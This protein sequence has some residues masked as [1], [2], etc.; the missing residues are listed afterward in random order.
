MGLAL[1]SNLPS[2]AASLLGGDVTTILIKQ[3]IRAQGSRKTPT[4]GKPVEKENPIRWLT[5]IPITVKLQ[6]VYT[7][8]SEVTQHAVES[9]EYFSD[10]VILRPIKLDLSFEVSN[11]DDGYAEYALELLEEMWRNRQPVGLETEHKILP[12]MVLTNLAVDNSV[13]LWKRLSC[14]A[15]FVAVKF[16]GIEEIKLTA[17]KVTPD[18]QT[19]GVDNHKSAEAATDHGYIAPK[20][21][22]LKTEGGKLVGSIIDLFKKAG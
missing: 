9:G 20:A 1:S 15:S 4:A 14:R 22:L 13:P 12:N 2:A 16:V 8:S 21:S 5:D 17:E 10:H 3:L 19:G 7:Y 11:W 6:E 18:V